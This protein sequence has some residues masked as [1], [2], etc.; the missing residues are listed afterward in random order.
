MSLEKLQQIVR[1]SHRVRNV[2]EELLVAKEV[3][4]RLHTELEKTDESRKIT[5]KLNFALKQ[6]LDTL[7]ESWDEKLT[8][9]KS[10]SLSP[11][12]LEVIPSSLPGNQ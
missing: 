11:S 4:V 7:K 9:V 1:D 6:Q 2:D 5:E 10:I 3:S 12:S 8:G